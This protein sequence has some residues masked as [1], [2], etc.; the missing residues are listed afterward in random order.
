MAC[1]QY[2]NLIQNSFIALKILCVLPIQLRFLIIIVFIRLSL[3]A[4]HLTTNHLVAPEQKLN[5]KL[6][7]GG[8]QKGSFHR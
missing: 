3:L 5:F 1:I 2:C 8:H 6:W 7:L 4:W